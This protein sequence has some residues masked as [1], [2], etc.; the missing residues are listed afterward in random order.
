VILCGGILEALLSRA[1][2]RTGSAAVPGRPLLATL[3]AA[4]TRRRLLKKDSLRLGPA[5]QAF[6]TLIQPGRAPARR[7][8]R[9]REAEQPSTR[10]GPPPAT[11]NDQQDAENPPS[12]L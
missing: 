9:L 5:L 7:P 10:Y 2:T 8:R 6:R 12:Q 1:L 3:V 4:A 11:A